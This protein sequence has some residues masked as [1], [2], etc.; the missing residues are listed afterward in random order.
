MNLKISPSFDRDAKKA[1]KEIIIG[2]QSTISAIINARSL[3]EIPRLK[4]L[5]GSKNAY[6]I[7]IEDYRLGLLLENDCVILKRLLSR[8]DVYKFFP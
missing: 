5:S 2:L 8:K 6:R 4:K 7:R 3:S 1:P